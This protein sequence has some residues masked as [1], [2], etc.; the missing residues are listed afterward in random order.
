MKCFCNT[1]G[2]GRKYCPVHHIRSTG[3]N[4][5]T[6]IKRSS[7]TL[8]QNDGTRELNVADMRPVDLDWSNE[9]LDAMTQEELWTTAN[10]LHLPQ[11]APDVVQVIST[12]VELKRHIKAYLGRYSEQTL[13]ENYYKLYPTMRPISP[14]R[15]IFET[16]PPDNNVLMEHTNV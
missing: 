14:R 9:E 5:F 4:N 12:V 11:M 15:V 2:L 3:A 8:S 6:F 1:P 13:E 10:L 16:K 7:K